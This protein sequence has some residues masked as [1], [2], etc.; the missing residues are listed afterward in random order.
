MTLEQSAREVVQAC[1]PLLAKTPRSMIDTE[2]AQML[3]RARDALIQLAT[4][5]DGESP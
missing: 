3:D 5:L 2:Q 4:L 1:G